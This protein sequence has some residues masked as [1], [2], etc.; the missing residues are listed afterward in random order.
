M[1]DGAAT[2]NHMRKTVI[3]LMLGALLV[4]SNGCATSST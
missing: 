2:E 1:A 3:V 4:Q